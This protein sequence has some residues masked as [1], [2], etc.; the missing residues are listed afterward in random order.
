MALAYASWRCAAS[1]A[2]L[3]SLALITQLGDRHLLP[4]S[5]SPAIQDPLLG[6][7]N[8][9]QKAHPERLSMTNGHVRLNYRSAALA[10]PRP[11]PCPQKAE[12]AFEAWKSNYA[13]VAAHN[14]AGKPYKVGGEHNLSPG[15]RTP[16]RSRRSRRRSLT[17]WP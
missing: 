16:I 6:E 10:R 9:W 13:H 7:Y 3:A 1:V 14:A 5:L 12:A 17:S 4:R 8:A 15:W 11:D 2:R